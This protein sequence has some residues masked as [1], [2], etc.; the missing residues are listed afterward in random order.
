[1]T[2]EVKVSAYTVSRIPD[3]TPDHTAWSIVVEAS[4][5]GK[6]AVRNIGRCLNKKGQWEHEPLPSNRTDKW[7]KT[8]RWDNP[9]DAI[10]AAVAAEPTLT[11]NGMT[12]SDVM[13]RH[14]GVRW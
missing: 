14:A 1:M 3:D 6:W 4:G 8:V 7:L 10:A 5:H 2:A 9:E 11:W 13:A 12:P